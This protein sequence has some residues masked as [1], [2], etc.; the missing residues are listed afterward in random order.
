MQF[1]LDKNQKSTLLE[2]A[3]EQLLAALHAGK[4][5]AGDR[6]PSVRQVVRHS[7]INIKTALSIYQRLKREGYVDLRMGS[8]AYVSDIESADLEQA[9]CLS[10]LRLIKSTL[11]Q[12]GQL[13]LDPHEYSE[14]VQRYVEKSRLGSVC[15][16]VVEC[17]E[18]QI[19]VFS[20]RYIRARK[21]S[22]HASREQ[23]PLLPRW[24][25]CDFA[26]CGQSLQHILQFGADRARKAGC[27]RILK[28]TPRIRVKVA[29][30]GRKA[31]SLP[32]C[33]CIFSCELHK[34][35]QTERKVSR[36]NT[37]SPRRR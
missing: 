8:G 24:P 35:P 17:N 26:G 4:V 21:R 37:L 20:S 32:R 36:R 31:V 23:R 10:I 1:S 30:W 16:A 14:L 34:M 2:Q 19:N 5:H 7:S 3:R 33:T 11:S 18:E 6:L 28:V 22:L 29:D 27:R 15:L 25:L 12:A 9:Y 13:K